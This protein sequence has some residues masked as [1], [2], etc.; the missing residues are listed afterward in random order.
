MIG[1]IVELTHCEPLG[2]VTLAGTEKRLEGVVCRN[3]ESSE[4]GQELPTDVEEDEE[5]VECDQAEEPVDLGESGLLLQVVQ[6]FILRELDVGRSVGGS[7][8]MGASARL[9][10]ASSV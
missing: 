5:E 7:K 4:V 3:H 6:N 2:I 9:T 1:D 10:S 8:N